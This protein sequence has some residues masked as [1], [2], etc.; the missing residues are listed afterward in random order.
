MNCAFK[1]KKNRYFIL[2]F[3]ALLSFNA[4]YSIDLKQIVSSGYSFLANQTSQLKETLFSNKYLT[5][6]S[7][8]ASLIAGYF[9][10]KKCASYISNKLFERSIYS[11]ETADHEK[12]NAFVET[13]KKSTNQEQ[14]KII[15]TIKTSAKKNNII[16]NVLFKS[17]DLFAPYACWLE[18][19]IPSALALNKEKTILAI[20]TSHTHKNGSTILFKD[21]ETLQTISTIIIDNQYGNTVRSLTFHPTKP[22]IAVGLIQKVKI[23]DNKY[24]SESYL[25]I[26]SI[27]N[28]HKPVFVQ[29]EFMPDWPVA[30]H[31]NSN[32]DFLAVACDDRNIKI[33]ATD[34]LQL[35]KEFKFSSEK[36]YNYPLHVQFNYDGSLLLASGFDGILQVFDCQTGKPVFD[37]T[38]NDQRS[39]QLVSSCFHPHHKDVI[40]YSEKQNNELFIN[41]FNISQQKSIKKINISAYHKTLSHLSIDDKGECLVARE[42]IEKPIIT[43]WNIQT[44]QCIFSYENQ[45][46]L[47]Q[48]NF[49][50]NPIFSKD[51]NCFMGFGL[52]DPSGINHREFH[53]NDVTY[54]IPI[55]KQQGIIIKIS[56]SNDVNQFSD[57]LIDTLVANIKAN[58]LN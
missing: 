8:A 51:G 14:Q 57:I 17:P 20:G 37:S 25:L 54:K 13:F 27:K 7:I 28:P 36:K 2:F 40:I 45:S 1:F 53:Q 15:D 55:I 41:F 46:H 6:G 29:K 49:F 26:Y 23:S 32:G 50:C 38:D 4:S 22:L 11:L 18:N 56:R 47:P 39:K 35:I 48:Y 24:A 5:A 42:E 30:L 12:V 19:E 21:P 43:I 52:P 33:Y 9:V 3:I 34:T 10:T 58:N 44:E 31:F 16:R